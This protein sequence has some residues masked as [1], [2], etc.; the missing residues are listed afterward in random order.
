MI[1]YNRIYL[2]HN[3]RL[4]SLSITDIFQDWESI[5]QLL[6]RA[7]LA[8]LVSLSLQFTVQ[9]TSESREIPWCRLWEIMQVN[10][11]Q[12]EVVEIDL[13]LLQTTVEPRSR[14]PAKTK[15]PNKVQR[16]E[17]ND[18]IRGS[19]NRWVAEKLKTPWD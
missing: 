16:K 4:R 15:T 13:L 8:S 11:A 6:E 2:S 14:G 1:Y 19:C 17:L 7:K 12:L 3:T 5:L 9:Q 10:F 18:I